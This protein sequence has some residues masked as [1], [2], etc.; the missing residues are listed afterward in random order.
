[1]VVVVVVDRRSCTSQREIFSSSMTAITTNGAAIKHL[2]NANM[3][4]NKY[5]FINIAKLEE[6]PIG[7]R[8]PFV[9]LFGRL[10]IAIL[11][12]VYGNVAYN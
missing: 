2:I 12:L 9:R 4:A 11:L 10:G 8:A 7:F 1:M 3:I 5:V 6:V